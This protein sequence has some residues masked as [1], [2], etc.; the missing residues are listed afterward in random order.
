MSDPRVERFADLLVNYSTRVQ[1][2]DRVFLEAEPPAT[3]L[4]I[5]LYERILHAGGHPHLIMRMTELKA[6]VM[7][8]GNDDQIDFPPT[9]LKLAYETFD[10]RIRIHSMSNSKALTGV[11]KARFARRQRTLQPILR[12]QMERGSKKEL[13]WVTT[14]FPT[15]AY[16]QDAEMSLEEYENFVYQAC[17]VDD[18]DVDAIAYWVG[19]KDELASVV[20]AL[21]G[22]DKVHVR[23][24]NCDLSLSIKDRIFK[25]S[26]GEHNMPDGEVFTGP[27]EESVNGWV[28]FTYPAIWQGSS[29]DGVELKFS[30]GGV[31]EAKASKNET[32]LKEMINTDPGARYLGEFAIGTNFGIDRFTGNILFDEKIGGTFHL[33][34]GAGYP[35]TGSKNQSAIHWDMIC[36]MRQD[37]EI[38]V[39]GETIYKD[40][41]FLI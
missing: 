31:V 1:P 3:P 14:L 15:N 30:Q 20:G 32:F 11:D 34:L 25:S 9:F 6:A 4:T 19:V 24:P 8:H 5:A 26:Y 39:D 10:A 27:V 29:A 33:A 36:D 38:I 21:A 2:G 18:P 13:K 40:G 37:S 23:G 35:E 28:R 16:A 12:T 17:H 22:H 41:V 7:N